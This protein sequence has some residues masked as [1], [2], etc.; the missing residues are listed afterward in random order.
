MRWG[1]GDDIESCNRC[2]MVNFIGFRNNGSRYSMSSILALS[3]SPHLLILLSSNEL[4]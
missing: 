2:S 1:D 4:S 3:P